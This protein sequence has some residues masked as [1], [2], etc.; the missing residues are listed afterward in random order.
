M[1]QYDNTHHT[2]IYLS[3]I[4][5]SK[6]NQRYLEMLPCGVMIFKYFQ[7]HMFKKDFKS[8]FQAQGIAL[9]VIPSL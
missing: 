2:P 9:L 1:A 4:S 7:K 5:Q 6:C 3:Y 8:K